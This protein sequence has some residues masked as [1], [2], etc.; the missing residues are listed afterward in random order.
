MNIVN[1]MKRIGITNKHVITE[2]MDK[3][4]Q[5]ICLER[6]N[7]RE[8]CALDPTSGECAAAWEA[9]EE[10]IKASR[11]HQSKLDEFCYE[12]PDTAECRIYDV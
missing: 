1:I 12:H 11:K 5:D 6:K 2:N 7:A 10:L 8:V 9:V 4:Q 3:L